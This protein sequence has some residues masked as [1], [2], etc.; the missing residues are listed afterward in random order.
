LL[1]KAAILKKEI[2]IKKL[3]LELITGKQKNSQKVF[4][5]TLVFLVVFLFSGQKGQAQ[6]VAADYTFA[7]ATGVTYTP[8]TT[9]TSVVGPGT[10]TGITAFSA[11]AN[12]QVT[13][14]FT[15]VYNNINYTNVY[16]SDNGFI[17]LG[18]IAPVPS[19]FIPISGGA[20][21]AAIAG[22]AIDL[23]GTVPTSRVSYQTIGTPGSQTFVVQYQ[24]L[25]RWGGSPVAGLRPGLMNFQIRLNQA[26][27]SV[28]VIYKDFTG[29]DA[30]AVNGQVGLRGL[31]NLDYNNRRTAGLTFSTNIAGT[32]NTQTVTTNSTY[33]PLPGTQFKWTP[34]FNATALAASMAGDNTTVNIS[35]T[36][37]NLLAFPGTYDYEVRTSGG[38]GTGASGLFASGTTTSTPIAVPGLAFGT[39]YTI[40]LKSSCK[41]ASAVLS[42]TVTPSCSAQNIPYTQNFESITAP[43][44]PACNTVQAV[45]GALMRTRDNTSTAY[46]G[47]NSKNMITGNQN[48]TD[49][50]Y[51]TQGLNLV[52]G[53]TYRLSYKYGGSREAPQFVQKMRVYYG[54][55]ANSDTNITAAEMT[56]LL[57]D[58][59]DIKESP[60]TFILNFTPTVSQAYYIGFQAYQNVINNGFLQLDDISVTLGTCIP[61]TPT[62]P[63]GQIT[64]NSAII[65]WSAAPNPS[66]GYEYYFSSSPTAP[67]STTPASG[68]TAVG[69]IT[70]LL[71]G[72]TPA[73]TYYFWVRSLCGGGD[74]SQWSASGTFTTLTA[75]VLPCS[76]NPGSVDSNGIINVTVGSINNTTGRETGNY[77]NYSNLI[78]NIAQNTTVNMSLTYSILGFLGGGYFTRI[79]IDFND[80]GDFFDAG[81]TVFDNGG[82]ELP[83]GLN[84]ISFNVPAAAPLGQHR[85]RIGG[86]DSNNLSQIV[87][88]ATANGPCYTGA[89]GTF[90][91]YSV[92]VTV[93]PPTLSV[94]DAS[95]ATSVTICSGSCSPLVSVTTGFAAGSNYS[96]SPNTGISG[97]LAGGFTF[98]PTTTTTYT[99]TATETTG[100][101]LSN[102]AT[103]VVNVK[104]NPTPISIA[105]VA[106]VFCQGV[107]QAL[108]ATG[109]IISGVTIL[110]ENFNSAPTTF[111][112]V[113]N[114]VNGNAALAYWTLRPS[115]YS[116]PAA[117]T[118][119]PM[120]ISSND[121]SQFYMT[122]S[123]IQGSAG[124]TNEQLISPVFS[125][126]G[127]TDATLSFWHYYKGF[128]NGSAQ[129]QVSTNGGGTWATLPG[130]TWTTATVGSP[131]GFVNV[132]LDLSSY[133][134]AGN[135]N[136]NMMIRFVYVSNYGYRWCVDNV[137]IT[138]SNSSTV[139]WTPATELWLDP[140]G[141][142]TP[143]TGTGTSVVYAK[144]S[145]SRVYTATATTL[146][147]PA[148][149][150][151][152]TVSVTVTPLS[153][154]TATGDQVVNC[155]N[156][157]SSNITLTGYFPSALSSIARWEWANNSLFSGVTTIPGSANLDTLTPAFLGTIGGTTYIRAVIIDC[158]TLY[159]NTVTLTVPAATFNAGV[160]TP[161]VPSP[162]DRVVIST[163]TYTVSNDES[164]CSM[165]VLNGAS[166]IVNS[167]VT[168]TIDKTL[169]VASAGNVT[170][171]N[172]ASLM[173]NS[174]ATTNMN[175]GNITYRRDVSIRKFDYTYWSSPVVTTLVSF[176][177]YTLSDKYLRWDANAYNWLY[178]NNNTAMTA[179]VGYA[180]RGPQLQS[181]LITPWPAASALPWTGSF[182]GRPNNG[183]Y[184]VTIFR[185]SAINNR[186]LIGNPYP[187]AISADA[188]MDGN[189]PTLGALGVGTSLYFWTHNTA[190]TAGNYN[191]ADYAVYNRTGSTAGAPGLNNTPPT[192]II[193]SGQAFMI[194]AV[195]PGV[196]TFRNSMRVSG[197]NTLFYRSTNQSSATSSTFEKNRLWLD[198]S[199]SNGE[200]KQL[201]VGYIQ[202]ATNEYEDG[203][204]APLFE[205]GNSVSFYSIIPNN[206]LIIQGRA[207][208][209][210]QSDIVPL[211]YKASSPTSFQI[212]LTRFDGLFE[213]QNVGVYLEDTFLNVI[214]NLKQAPYTFV[215]E[216]GTFDNRFILRYT[217]SSLSVNPVVFNGNAVIA[218]KKNESLYVKSINNLMKS[219]QVYDVRGRLITEKDY[220]NGNEVVFENLSIAQ[221]VLMVQIIAMD[222][223]KV[224]KKIIY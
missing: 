199:N 193:S 79:W 42:A 59:N 104:N 21:T 68:M 169:N 161:S 191:P 187:S 176:S 85:M 112:T 113:N 28:E 33:F 31:T 48:V 132:T 78:T 95:S 14:P 134:T 75:P 105:P 88:P 30:T 97:S 181:D 56:T 164:F 9:G 50:W 58:H 20:H 139:V 192:G 211:G 198:F 91:D 127:F 180:I 204:D 159:S 3:L 153:A 2:M 108:T 24:D 12:T 52:A 190:I 61:P 182:V 213:D 51:F 26:D 16:I 34:C 93:A 185:P 102:T 66:D 145:A 72:L 45:T 74:K 142:T 212:A 70:N 38:F 80:D 8:I 114:S 32:A 201:L 60:L 206:N 183:D 202:N 178:L 174:A 197:S 18:D 196:V 111:S 35:W 117:N 98:C 47:F 100:S 101:Y 17:V 184:S 37:A 188:L 152:N 156:L 216:V 121:V 4:V 148:C 53:T 135:S 67:I 179:A 84:N 7:Q 82:V 163:G 205:A 77:G 209:F 173:Q 167:G 146:G 122:D 141:T 224:T 208:P 221:Q 124:N 119:D 137:R 115:P 40:Y 29:S 86:A 220:I 10:F 203:F 103:Y 110:E 23:R 36:N 222:G 69:N 219:V 218:Y 109:G 158:G 143:Y 150:A 165:Q 43:A 89:Y 54:N 5:T 123:D 1:H 94:L 73:T 62:M 168:L 125:L 160:W 195:N 99:L 215:T 140:T 41:P 44:V 39:P 106:P 157:L 175:T 200:Y 217:D 144:M 162:G 194:A 126:V 189:V 128:S 149:S 207:L 81:E 27:G 154:G 49:T 214:H 172:G 64:S 166:V 133:A 118:D 186:N 210:V 22:Y 147:L 25:Q 138:G 223:S 155:G 19:S 120:S 130:A 131:S 55:D 87:L 171:N 151:S 6:N 57:A 90:E 11:L 63:V 96:W 92:Y 129:V 107:A 177:P 46:Y 83:N 71:S 65:A 15:F 76:P 116:I 136:S 13:L 170:F